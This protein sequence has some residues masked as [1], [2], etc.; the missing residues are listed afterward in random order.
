MHI[1]EGV[2]A[3]PVLI[4]GAAATTVGTFLGLRKLSPERIPQVALLSAAFFVASLVHVPLGPSSVHLVLNG[5]V[6]IILGLATF[7]ALLVALFLQAI[8][9]QF[10][11]LTTLGVNTFNMAFGG[12]VV[13]YLFRPLI[14]LFRPLIKSQKPLLVGIGA[15]LSGA[16]AILI[17]G[18]LVALELVFTGESFYTS[19]K[20]ILAAHLPVMLIEGIITVLLVSFLKKVRPEIF[21]K[22]E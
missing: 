7:P 16:L 8:L 21:L 22:E 18:I 13:Y 12:V 2:L 19:A 15:F 3:A 6:G 17:S 9:F 1:S 11:G 20:L 14:Y 5:L 10:G 4:A